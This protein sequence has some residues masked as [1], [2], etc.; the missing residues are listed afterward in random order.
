VRVA[1]EALR[2]AERALDTERGKSRRALDSIEPVFEGDA[3]ARTHLEGR[4]REVLDRDP[5]AFFAAMAADVA[6]WTERVRVRDGARARRAELDTAMAKLRGLAEQ[7]A[8]AATSAAGARVARERA[9]AALAEQRAELFGGRA[10]ADVRA[11]LEGA[12]RA[13][14]AAVDEA[15]GAGE[16]A[17]VQRAAAVARAQQVR[18]QLAAHATERAKALEDFGTEV[19]PDL[20]AVRAA[21]HDIEVAHRELVV[22]LRMDDQ[23]RRAAA[24][25]LARVESQR[26]AA[27][28]WMALSEL[29]GSSDGKKFRV[30][31]QSLTLDALL[32]HANRHLDELAPRYRL[33]RVPG[34]DL[35]LQVIDRD[36]GDEVRSVNSLSGGE[37]FLVS[38]ALAL[39]L[40]SVSAK[41]TQ[42]DS[43]L[44][45]EG[46]GTLDPDTLEVALATLDTLQ[47]TGRKVGL[48]SH[49]P[50]LAERIGVQVQVVPAGAGKSTVTVVAG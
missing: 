13:A 44:I 5:D 31:A 43:L 19:A 27:D 18:N 2:E 26:G 34:Y 8:E 1:A 22:Q 39:A 40:S 6:A 9:C 42:V 16:R 12:V 50:G 36:L 14:G 7:R 41:D 32:A 37:S 33:V 46:F 49:I 23:A 20:D 29:I 38:L 11:E 3:A 24:E 28:L 10:T 25:V 4:W 17:N 35:D 15:R 48:I 47:A 21:L 45:D 30:F